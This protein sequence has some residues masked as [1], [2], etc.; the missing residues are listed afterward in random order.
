[1]TI[2]RNEYLIQVI[3]DTIAY[4]YPNIGSVILMNQ[5]GWNIDLRWPDGEYVNSDDFTSLEGVKLSDEDLMRA[6][7]IARQLLSI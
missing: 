5:R 7:K 1:M 6:V 3:A 2:D 4:I